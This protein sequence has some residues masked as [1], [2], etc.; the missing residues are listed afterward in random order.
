MILEV[1]LSSHMTGKKPEQIQLIKHY[2]WFGNRKA[3]V[4]DR[5]LPGFFLFLFTTEPSKNPEKKSS[6]LERSNLP[7]KQALR[8]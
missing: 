7:D 2:F 8:H 1:R 3:A 6:E 5:N 4:P